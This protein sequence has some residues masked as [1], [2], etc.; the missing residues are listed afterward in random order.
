MDAG[1]VAGVLCSL[2]E[3]EL[4]L[5]EL[6]RVIRPGGELRF[7][8]HVRAPGAALAEL[9]HLLDATLWPRLFGGCHPDRDT[10]A[11]IMRAGF[12]IE[13]CDRFSFHPTLLSIPVAPRILGSARRR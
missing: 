7:Y 8:E 3:P 13:A 10:E 6:A 12:A 5:G 1:V 4:G 11:T 2:P 9:Q